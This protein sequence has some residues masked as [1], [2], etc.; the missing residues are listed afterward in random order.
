MKCLAI[1]L[2]ADM[3]MHIC[4]RSDDC[5]LANKP[6]V[7][8]W[9]SFAAAS[10]HRHRSDGKGQHQAHRISLFYHA[11]KYSHD[12]EAPKETSR[13]FS[14]AETTLPYVSNTNHARTMLVN[15]EHS[16]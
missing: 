7:L 8:L 5:H 14:T 11:I 9:P 10:R 16:S 15:A 6:S 13:D 1:W 3:C 2:S 4:H 12:L